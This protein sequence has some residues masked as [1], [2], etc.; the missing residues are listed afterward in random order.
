MSAS[1]DKI[2]RKQQ[3]A[4]GTDKRSVA[5]AK[6][7]AEHRKT[8]ITY[9]IVA[10]VLVVFFAFVFIY[11]SSW[12]SRHTTAVTI[13]GED[14]SVAE[15]NYYY[16]N[17]Y[18]SFYNTY[19]SYMSYGLFFNPN[20]SLADQEYSEGYSWRQYFL[21]TAVDQMAQVQMLNDEAEAA[22]FTLSEEQQAAYESE[23]EDLKTAW[24]GLGYSNLKQFINLTYGK[25]VDEAM[26]E[27]ELYRSYVASAYSE[28]VY[29]SYSYTDQEL[30][31]KYDELADQLD[32]IEYAYYYVPAPDDGDDAETEPADD[33]A[34]VLD[35][36]AALVAIDGTDADTF[37]DYLA[38]NA[39]GA[40][41]TVQTLPGSSLS[42]LYADW[43]L[44]GIR[45]PGDATVV[46]DDD[47][48]SYIVMFLSRDDNDYPT[49][50]FRH[51]LIQAE[52]TDG[53]G[54]FSQE[55]IDAAEAEAQDLYA[56][57]QAGDATEDSFAEMA[58][59]YSDDGG[60]N[61]VGGLYENV[62]KGAMVDPINDWLFE[63]GRKAGDTTVVSYN[64]PSYTGTHV[65]YFTGAS[66]QTYALYQAEQQ[67]RADQYNTWQDDQMSSYEPVTAH[68]GM[69]GKNH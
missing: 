1:K 42:A 9:S 59:E 54:T 52:D 63:A 4:A 40:E 24:Q 32:M 38:E 3:V 6:E 14:Y 58:N 37:R 48:S 17:A 13:D 27:R 55:E 29:N 41:P 7:K 50:G 61:T 12:P 43:L 68:L 20:E 34:S 30:A 22:G 11:N 57:W 53:D 49:V 64:G 25:G 21:D 62:F 28:S 66:D 33:N 46:E 5:A 26:V 15:L 69:A 60:S 35:T 10:V 67:L 18:L 8:T 39:D 51:I 2:N 16:S 56:Q 47:G 19:S 31:A 45:L 65:V 44:N 36:H 23:L